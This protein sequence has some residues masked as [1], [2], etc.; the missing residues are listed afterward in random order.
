[1]NNDDMGGVPKILICAA[2]GIPDTGHS[3][4]TNAP[5]QPCALPRPCFIHQQ[6]DRKCG[7]RKGTEAAV[8]RRRPARLQQPALHNAL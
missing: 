5:G 4:H 7:S 1:M 6:A 8:G 2:G 3:P